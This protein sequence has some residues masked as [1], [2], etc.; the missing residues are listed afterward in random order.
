MAPKDGGFQSQF[1]DW[2]NRIDKL[3][4]QIHDAP[5]H[6]QA[7]PSFLSF[8]VRPSLNA[9]VAVTAAALI[10]HSAHALIISDDVN[11]SVVYNAT[12]LPDEANP[13]W[14]PM[15]GA[16]VGT[17]SVA[18]NVLT[19]STEANG[20]RYYRISNTSI[21]NGGTTTG[22]TIEFSLRVES[23][24]DGATNA[25]VIYFTT[26]GKGYG[27]FFRPNEISYQAGAN[28]PVHF[29]DTTSDFNRYRI[30][31]SGAG[32]ASLYV[33]NEVTPLISGYTG[34]ALGTQS[35]LIY[36][37]DAS[38]SSIGGVVH[39]EYMAF[40]NSEMVAPIPEAGSVMLLLLGGG[41][42]AGGARWTA[43]RRANNESTAQ[44]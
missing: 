40:T 43:R 6:D 27:F 25:T 24:A 16:P 18:N 12:Q 13:A 38:N 30:T 39:W 26:G 41:L 1:R 17:S 10:P 33:N 14:A 31:L 35:N 36:F 4:H 19:M 22:S 8:A 23:L 32:E 37:G 3:I 34:T 11:F 29:F 5:H 42:A 20:N 28:P 21:W 9:L 2:K 44:A 15:S 7:L